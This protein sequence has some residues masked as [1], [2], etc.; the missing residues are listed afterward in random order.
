MRTP[1][2]GEELMLNKNM[3]VEQFLP[4]DVQRGL[5]EE[6]MAVYRSPFPDPESRVPML[7]W[8]RSIPIGGE[9]ADVAE[10]VEA[11]KAW[12]MTSELPKLHLY[13]EPGGINPPHIAEYFHEQGVPSYES[14]FIG[15]GG[16]FI[17]EDYP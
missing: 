8:V 6:E 11:Y 13:V 9:P 15:E 7:T 3:F 17:Q 12:F 16:H 2:M 10:R 1:G 4:N 14:V 5:T